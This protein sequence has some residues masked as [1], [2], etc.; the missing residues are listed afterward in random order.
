MQLNEIKKI[1]IIG[2]GTMGSGIAQVSALAGYETILF[3][4]EPRML[5]R[6][7]ASIEANLAEAVKRNKLSANAQQAALSRIYTT[8]FFADLQADV[9]IEAIIENLDIKLEAFQQIAKNN[10]PNCILATNTSSIPITRLAAHL[11]NPERIVGMHF[12]NP[13][14]LM[15]LVEVIA[16]PSTSPQVVETIRQLTEK[17]GKVPVTANDAPGFIVNRVA[18]HYYVEALQL[19]EEGVADHQT[20]DALLESCG[21]K[22]GAFK[23]MDLIGVDVNFS[24]TKSMFDSFHYAPR[25]RPSR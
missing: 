21:F 5:P 20:I 25:F 2:A 13:A 7:M 16:A 6:A 4:I 3:D 17:M 9:F 12:F 22:M 24:V 15:R 18:R 19:L 23:L 11:P 8:N 1:A 14:H 10:A